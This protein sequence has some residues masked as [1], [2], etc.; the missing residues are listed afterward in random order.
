MSSPVSLGRAWANPA[1][2]T[3]ALVAA[4]ERPRV[5]VITHPGNPAFPVEVPAVVRAARDLGVA[6][7]INNASFVHTRPGSYETCSAIAAE[8]ARSGGVV[9]L[10]S[11]AHVACHVGQVESAWKV[12]AA[13]GVLPE[14]VVNRTYTGL[15]RFLGIEAGP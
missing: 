1:R 12:A 7:E 10:S 6:V 11:D 8:V 13:A 9:C 3:R 5:R 14:Q 2:N 15:A 4:M